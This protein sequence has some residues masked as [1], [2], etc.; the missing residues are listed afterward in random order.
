MPL[1]SR[2]LLVCACGTGAAVLVGQGVVLMTDPVIARPADRSLV[3]VAVAVCAALAVVGAVALGRS[4]A[5]ALLPAAVVAA[6][7][8][9]LGPLASVGLNGTRWGFNGLW[10]DAGFRAEA[11]ERFAVS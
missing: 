2:T 4:R 9:L 1:T 11:A 7:S 3:R 10:S 8:S 6:P 5:R